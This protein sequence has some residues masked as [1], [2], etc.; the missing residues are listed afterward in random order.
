MS[1]DVWWMALA[2]VPS[3]LSCNFSF[4]ISRTLCCRLELFSRFGKWVLVF[5]TE[6][7]FSIIFPRDG[8]GELEPFPPPTAVSMLGTPS[9][10]VERSRPPM[11]LY[12]KE[13]ISFFI[14][15]LRNS[16]SFIRISSSSCILLSTENN[17]ASFKEAGS[18]STLLQSWYLSI[19]FCAFKLT[20]S[21][22]MSYF[23]KYLQ[24]TVLIWLN[25]FSYLA[26]VALRSFT[27]SSIFS[28]TKALISLNSLLICACNS[29]SFWLTAS[30]AIR[31]TSSMSVAISSSFSL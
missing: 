15:S 26:S 24:H 6:L 12:S 25:Y 13:Y 7:W 28:S 30:F 14:K 2:E 4:P 10:W 8:I 29:F 1:V 19:T 5:Y 22:S 23:S 31:F 17:L 18:I 27:I 3:K 16:Y 11:L 9:A 21:S 20:D